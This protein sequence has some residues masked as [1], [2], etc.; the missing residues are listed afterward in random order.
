MDILGYIGYAVL[1]FLAVT[2]T[3]GV[4][5]K[6]EA[7]IFTILGAL[8]FVSSAVFV[9]VFGINKFHSLW[10][11][12]TGFVFMYLNIFIAVRIPSLFRLLTFFGSVFA[13]IIR[14]GIPEEKIKAAQ[15]ADIK[16]TV[17]RWIK[18]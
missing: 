3:I 14:I 10:I 15:E 13:N 7:N 4:R 17:E 12:P 5:V 8:F 2:W 6:L 16:A 1:I 11:V 9:G 18:K